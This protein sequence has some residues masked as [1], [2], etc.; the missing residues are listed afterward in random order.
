[1]IEE[2]KSRPAARG[3]V[4]PG[5]TAA[6]AFA[7]GLVVG[8]RSLDQPVPP[9]PGPDLNSISARTAG[10]SIVTIPVRGV[11]IDGMRCYFDPDV[12]TEVGTVARV[13]FQLDGRAVVVWL[14]LPAAAP[15]EGHL[16]ISNSSDKGALLPQR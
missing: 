7:G 10:K 1:M 16:P 2:M 13:D 11:T 4:V 8:A 15:A 3:F 14:Q 6:I 9:S 5:L 12:P